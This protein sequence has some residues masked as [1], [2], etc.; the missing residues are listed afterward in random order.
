MEAEFVRQHLMRLPTA[1]N[2]ERTQEM[3]YSKYLA[4]YVQRGYHVAYNAEQFYRA[5]PQWGF[6]ELDDYWFADEAQA[7]E[8]EKQKARQS[9]PEGKHA[10]TQ[11]VLFISDERSARRW[12]WNF[13]AVPR[14][15]DEIYNAFVKALQTS[16]D[17]IP[18]PTVL[19]EEGFVR[20]NGHWKRPDTLTREE[21]ERKRQQ[22]LLRQFNDY[23]K[24]ARSGQRLKEVR[25]AAL[26][27]GFT[28]AY[29]EGRFGDIVTVGQK[30]D[31]RL[32]EDSPDLQDFIE[33]AEA[34][35]E[36]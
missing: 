32:L 18:E 2:V 12:L 20:T 31:R 23:R 36:A 14:T 16:E 11:D 26:L 10:H 7:N 29:R 1:A 19:L 21:L 17:E 9:A 4:Y 6:E 5:L 34:R 22:R 8:Y 13:L 25:K 30:L 28:E 3:L 27:A 33:I 35:L 15:Y 24:K